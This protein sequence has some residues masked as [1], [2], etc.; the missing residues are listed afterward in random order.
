MYYLKHEYYRSVLSDIK[1]EAQPS[2]LYLIKHDN[3]CFE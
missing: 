2:V 3:E 1:R